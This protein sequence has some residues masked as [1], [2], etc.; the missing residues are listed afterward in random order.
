MLIY[1][2]SGILNSMEY[3]DFEAE[4][5][6]ALRAIPARFRDKIS[7]VAFIVETEARR[8]SRGERPIRVGG[9]LL[10]LYQGIPLGQRGP[11]YSGVLP[12]KITIFQDAI[13]AVGQGDPERIRQIIRHTVWHE[14]GHYFG[15]SEAEVQRWERTQG[16]R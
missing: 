4:V 6:A 10:G 14:I 9:I 7:N 11:G 16:R 15:M 12:D 1:V 13:E 2:G 3:V 5:F 8:L